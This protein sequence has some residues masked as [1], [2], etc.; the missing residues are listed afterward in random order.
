MSNVVFPN[1]IS[2]ICERAFKDCSGLRNIII[3]PNVKI[4][5]Y[6]FNNCKNLENILLEASSDDEWTYDELIGP[7]CFSNC[8]KLSN[9]IIE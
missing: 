7:Y 3:P 6:A 1:S 4:N 9:A 2:I 5:E 8:N